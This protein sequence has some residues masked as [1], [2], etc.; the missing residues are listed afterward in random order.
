[1]K[2]YVKVFLWLVVTWALFSCSESPKE[3]SMLYGSWWG[4]EYKENGKNIWGEYLW[5]ADEY[6]EGEG[7]YVYWNQKNQYGYYRNIKY[8]EEVDK[9]QLHFW[10]LKGDSVWTTHYYNGAGV[11]GFTMSIT[12]NWT[13]GQMATFYRIKGGY[14]GLKAYTDSVFSSIPDPLYNFT[15]TWE[16]VKTNSQGKISE[17]LI[18]NFEKDQ[19]GAWISWDIGSKNTVVRT[20]VFSQTEQNISLRYADG[21]T[22]SLVALN[23]GDKTLWIFGVGDFTQITKPNDWQTYIAGKVNK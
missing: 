17:I 6:G 10:N 16:Y 22:L 7:K 13:T 21:T 19:T 11:Y 12:P 3:E 2:M 1:M 15:G 4:H 14:D 18:F 20:F 8:K 5:F 23:N 9:V